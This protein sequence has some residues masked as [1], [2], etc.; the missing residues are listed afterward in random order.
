MASYAGD[1]NYQGS[2]SGTVALTTSKAPTTLT[3]SGNPSPGIWGQQ[4]TLSASVGPY[5]DQ[6]HMTDGESVTFY[7]GKT[8]IG[9]TL[10]SGGVATLTTS[11]LKVG[12]H[13]LR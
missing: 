13:Y 5:P 2:S 3:L 6:G 11:S 12:T 7:D 4:V 9:S 1:K 10:L 8:N